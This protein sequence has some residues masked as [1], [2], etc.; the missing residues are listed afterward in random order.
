MKKRMKHAQ[1]V[2]SELTNLCKD[3]QDVFPVA[4]TSQQPLMEQWKSQTVLVMSSIFC[5][6]SVLSRVTFCFHIVKEFYTEV[7]QRV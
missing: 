6:G 4:Q 7:F 3:K 1:N 5:F 2:R